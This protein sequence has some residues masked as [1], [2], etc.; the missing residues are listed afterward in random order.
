MKIISFGIKN[1]YSFECEKIDF[2]SFNIIVG[3]NG[4]GKTN[5]IRSLKKI[6][7]RSNVNNE[8]INNDDDATKPITLPASSF[9]TKLDNLS[10][11]TITSDVKLDREK[12]STIMLNL[13]LSKEELKL[14]FEFIFKQNIEIEKIQNYDED[15]IFTILINW[16]VEYSDNI[17]PDLLIF[18]F[19][20]GFTFYYEKSSS[21]QITYIDKDKMALFFENEALLNIWDKIRKEDYCNENNFNNGGVNPETSER[22]PYL[23]Y[24]EIVSADDFIT[25]SDTSPV[26]YEY[27]IKKRSISDLLPKHENFL[28]IML[29]N[30]SNI[31][32]ILSISYYKSDEKKRVDPLMGN[33]FKYY[34]DDKPV[35]IKYLTLRSSSNFYLFQFPS[36]F[37]KKYFLDIYDVLFNEKI[38]RNSISLAFVPDI[39]L[40]LSNLVFGNI[41]IFNEIPDDEKTLAE[42]IFKLKN[43]DGFQNNY[44]EL[45][46]EFKNIF[47]KDLDFDVIL[48]NNNKIIKIKDNNKHFKLSD[49]ASGYFDVLSLLA[50]ISY[51]KDSVIIMDEPLTRLHHSKQRLIRKTLFENQNSNQII[52]VTHSSSFVNYEVI[53][54][55]KLIY[56][57]RNGNNSKVYQK[58]SS[59]EIPKSHLL[60]PDIFFSNYVLA[61]E[62]ATDEAVFKAISDAQSDLFWK[63][64][65]LILNMQ[66]KDSAYKFGIMMYQYGINFIVLVDRDFDEKGFVKKNN[67]DKGKF[68]PYPFENNKRDLTKSIYIISDNDVDM[69]HVLGELGY[70]GNRKGTGDYYNFIYNDI[71]KNN[72]GKIETTLL[73]NIINKIK[74]NLHI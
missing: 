27:D 17:N 39:W 45:K 5:I 72:P 1:L 42:K 4:G 31:K 63:N 32:K 37:D 57:K 18:R 29:N 68:H 54:N 71:M 47:S 43:L 34:K 23:M 36:V 40:F 22:W 49:S 13:L 65:I 44:E 19:P 11:S 7:N 38:N 56:V 2:D 46:N 9:K 26:A 55:N 48:N 64:D 51:K 41:I 60:N 6:I 67:I 58:T 53:R 24:N 59:D 62:G 14:L 25:Y 70:K 15:A 52:M 69:D 3:P 21:Q 16:P 35:S 66:G 50:E 61:V 8:K 74:E 12:K 28:N 10:Y 33:N 30:D 20:N 73:F